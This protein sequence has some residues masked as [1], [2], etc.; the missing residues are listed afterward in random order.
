MIRRDATT[1]DG[2]PGWVL[3]DQVEHARL[4]GDLARCWGAGEFAPLEPRDVVLPTIYRHDD[5][6][7][8]WDRDPGIDC[9]SGRP[10]AFTEMP[11]ETAQAL[12]SQSIANVA[13]LGPLSQYL[14]AG[15]FVALRSGGDRAQSKAAVEFTTRYRDLEDK[16]LRRWQMLDPRSNTT[17]SATRAL[18]HLQL[19]D[20]LSLWLC[21]AQIPKPHSWSTPSGPNV[22]LQSDD[23]S[24]VHVDPWPMTVDQLDL[25]V[26]GR[27]VPA[28]DYRG[29]KAMASVSESTI[30]LSWRLVPNRP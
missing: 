15:H 23:G 29:E 10:L 25:Q 3:I 7:V 11:V 20:S 9:V 22:S 24:I 5:G 2:S 18:R 12:W 8:D 30:T 6:W 1:S 16:W 4:A 14:V 19:F 21:C 27:I 13:S 28:T 26:S 17:E